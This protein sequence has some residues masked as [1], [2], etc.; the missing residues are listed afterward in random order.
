MR[1]AYWCGNA[2]AIQGM[3]TPAVCVVGGKDGH[4]N[5]LGRWPYELL[6]A[7][8]QAAQTFSERTPAAASTV[9]AHACT[10]SA[11]APP[12]P[13]PFSMAQQRRSQV[14]SSHIASMNMLRSA[15]AASG[16]PI[17]VPSD[18]QVT[19][20]CTKACLGT[21][22]LTMLCSHT[23]ERLFARKYK[24]EDVDTKGG[25]C[26]RAEQ[27]AVRTYGVLQPQGRVHFLWARFQAWR[28]GGPR[29]P[30][31]HRHAQAAHQHCKVRQQLLQHVPGRQAAR[32]LSWAAHRPFQQYLHTQTSRLTL[33]E[34]CILIFP[35]QQKL[36][37]CMKVS[38]GCAASHVCC[39]GTQAQGAPAA[40]GW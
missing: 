24:C 29:W 9:C 12:G 26:A 37:T 13:S 19:T 36:D 14:A 15:S 35:T 31:L 30:R 16:L 39:A 1:N 3:S 40:H 23:C 25:L 32:A 4:D 11:R 10:R 21:V 38:S 34:C 22:R 8:W 28:L 7:T 5:L 33:T 6:R 17:R 20:C 2:C 18:A 27:Q